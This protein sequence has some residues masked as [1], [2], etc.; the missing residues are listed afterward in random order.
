M[1]ISYSGPSVAAVFAAGV[2]NEAWSEASQIS[3]TA[4][5]QIK[6]TYQEAGKT[7]PLI[8]KPTDFDS[9]TAKPPVQPPLDTGGMRNAVND[10]RSVVDKTLIAKLAGGFE[11]FM[12]DYFPIGD[13]L[14]GAL[15][16]LNTALNDGGSGINTAVE[17]QIWQR[18]QDR[19]LRDASRADSEAMVS[20]SARGYPLPP[21]ALNG[22]L[23][24]NRLAAQAEIADSSRA[25]AIKSFETEI[26][27]TRFAVGK[28]LEFRVAAISSAG[29]YVKAL[30]LGPKLCADLSI[31]IMD[32]EA[33]LFSASEAFYRA[34]IAG[35]E[36]P[37][38]VAGIKAE[39][40]M[41]VQTME[42]EKELKQV[43][44]KVSVLQAGAQMA[45]TQAASLYNGFHGSVGL[46]GSESL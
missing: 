4:D 5:A 27:N 20:W 32:A 39:L 1:S 38:K 18:D 9:I 19:I 6:Q 37:L 14:S 11:Q 28:A 30:A 26:E 46:S 41:R 17:A 12:T 7:L 35:Y 44:E 24:R 13:E 2:L 10:A 22:A 42:R 43:S 45:A 8:I 33:K 36:L 29:E 31:S 15:A 40:N 25:A 23:A 3:R 34:Q 16:W 21:G